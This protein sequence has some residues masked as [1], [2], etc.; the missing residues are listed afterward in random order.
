MAGPAIAKR[1]IPA[2]VCQPSSPP[3]P[4]GAAS[5]VVPCP[6]PCQRQTVNSGLRLHSEVMPY[7]SASNMHIVCVVHLARGGWL[8][9]RVP[10]GEGVAVTSLFAREAVS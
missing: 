1:R 2:P 5:S 10:D 3:T 8:P 6:H 4:D 7:C 9:G